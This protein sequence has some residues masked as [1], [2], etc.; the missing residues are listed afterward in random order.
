MAGAA[1]SWR[2]GAWITG[3]GVETGPAISNSE[4]SATAL[5]PDLDALVA[6]GFTTRGFLISASLFTARAV[7]LTAFL[8]LPAR[9]GAAL[10]I[11]KSSMVKFSKS[12][13]KLAAG[14][15]GARDTPNA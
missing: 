2:M 4:G 11:S 13:L 10:L 6:R 3:D 15:C 12:T 1:G 5:D 9:N 7:F 14:S 8:G